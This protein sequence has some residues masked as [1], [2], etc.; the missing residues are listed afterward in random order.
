MSRKVLIGVSVLGHLALGAGVLVSGAWK[1][2]RL[3]SDFRGLTTL[4]VLSPPAPSGGPA[5]RPAQQLVPKQRAKKLVKETVQPR[6]PPPEP[7]AAA[8]TMPSE[9]GNGGGDGTGPGNG[10]GDP[11]STGTC[12]DGPCDE[13]A[14][15]E[16]PK[17]E[18]PVEPPQPPPPPYVPPTVLSGLRI[19]G[20][21]Q[22]HPPDSTKT[23][24]LREGR[25]QVKGMVKVC[26]SDRGD[27]ASATIVA[28]TKFAEYDQRLLSAIRTWRYRPYMVNQSP[29]PAC[30]MVTFVYSIR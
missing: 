29:I 27:V 10:A 9:P 24:M 6:V 13:T 8:A 20:D 5:D 22:V 23:Q 4:A 21:P 2:E 14:A 1:L 7:V 18:P 15:P 30:G 25:P 19:S 12:T 3:D 28:S 26:L 16:P 11:E 17:P